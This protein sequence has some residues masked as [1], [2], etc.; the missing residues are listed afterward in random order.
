MLK[1]IE[2]FDFNDLACC[3]SMIMSSESILE[4]SLW[5]FNHA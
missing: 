3:G 2:K 4:K 5:W 1:C